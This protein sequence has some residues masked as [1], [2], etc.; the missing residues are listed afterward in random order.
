MDIQEF[1]NELNKNNKVKRANSQLTLGSLIKQLEEFPKD[2]KIVDL[3]D[4]HSYRGYYS[5]L[6]FTFG[7]PITVSDLAKKLKTD[8]LNNEFYGYKGGDFLMDENT[9]LWFSTYGSTG[10]KLLSIN[11]DN[12]DLYSFNLEE[13][14]F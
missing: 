6:A 2:Q 11:K 5:D 8:C 10:E 3:V 1:I 9:P 13:D 12:P 4:A 7:N 14:I